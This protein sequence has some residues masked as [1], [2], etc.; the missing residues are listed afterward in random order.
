MGTIVVV[1]AHH[2]EVESVAFKGC[3]N[4]IVGSLL[5]AAEDGLLAILDDTNPRTRHI[6]ITQTSHI[7]VFHTL[8]IE[9]DS[10]NR[11][12]TD[13]P[14]GQGVASPHQLFGRHRL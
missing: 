3:V 1:V 7:A 8:G 11:S 14:L 2:A 5:E 10:G 13:D 6:D 9:F 4:G 12:R